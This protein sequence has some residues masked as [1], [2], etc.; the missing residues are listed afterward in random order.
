MQFKTFKEINNYFKNDVSCLH[1]LEE[2]RWPD[3]IIKCPR[4][5]AGDPDINGNSY[6]C[7][8]CGSKFD[9]GYKSSFTKRGATIKQRFLIWWCYYN[10]QLKPDERIHL[11]DLA[12]KLNTT[13]S[14]VYPNTNYAKLFYKKHK[15][16]PKNFMVIEGDTRPV[17]PIEQWTKKP[18]KKSKEKIPYNTAKKLKDLARMAKMFK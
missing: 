17:L 6:K 16:D 2:Q 12:R 4:C 18:K 1:Y 15:P 11:P 9:A 14:I 7:K 10:G 3:G 5:A 8:N 13:F